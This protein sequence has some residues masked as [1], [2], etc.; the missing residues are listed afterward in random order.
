VLARQ[1]RLKAVSSV[2]DSAENIRTIL[3]VDDEPDV[4]RLIESILS[5]GGY[6]VIPARDATKAIEAFE[7]MSERPDLILTDVVMPGMSGPMLVDHLLG[8]QPEL[9]VLFMSGYDDRQVVQRYVVERGF[10]LITKPFTVKS[11]RSEVES[12]I[13]TD[14]A[15]ESKH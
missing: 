10:R 13:Q 11:L 3:V 2:P 7:K 12:M 15:A 6:R 9:R 14:G 8:L 4:L 1:A 5:D